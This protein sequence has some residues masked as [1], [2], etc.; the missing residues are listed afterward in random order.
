MMVVL[1]REARRTV[2][3]QLTAHCQWCCRI[4]NRKELFRLKHGPIDYWFCDRDHAELWLEFRH[5]PET[6]KLCRMLPRERAEH[7]AGRSMEAQISALY[8]RECDHS[9]R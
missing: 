8:P 4:A 1:P 2:T 6:Y 5:R 7:L 3:P 9:E